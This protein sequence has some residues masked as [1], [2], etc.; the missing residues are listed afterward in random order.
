MATTPST[1][2][3]KTTTSANGS[4]PAARKPAARKPAAVKTA[5]ARST[6]ARKGATTRGVNKTKI[7]AQAVRADAKIVSDD[8]LSTGRSAALLAGNYAERAAY[9]Q[10]G[11]V[12]TARDRVVGTVED[13]RT[14]SR[15]VRMSGA[16]L[17]ESH[18]HDVKI[19]KE[20]P[21]YEAR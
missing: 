10:V 19:T 21:N 11:A 12:L 17:R 16:G 8:A 14:K 18:P 6:A 7:D 5:A 9:V 13:L 1:T 15:F 4:K 2:P 20:A 3:R